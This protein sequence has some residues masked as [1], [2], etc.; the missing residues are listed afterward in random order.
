MRGGGVSLTGGRGQKRG[1]QYFTASDGDGQAL[2]PSI[3]ARTA[4]VLALMIRH[5]TS[6]IAH[7][8]QFLL[9]A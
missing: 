2:P 6:K 7:T 9:V 4:P 1:W 3:G 8:L 5:Q